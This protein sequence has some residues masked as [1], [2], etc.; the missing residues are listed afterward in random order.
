MIK[1]KNEEEIKRIR[2]SCKML[3]EVYAE[4]IPNVEPGISTKEIDRISYDLITKK[5]GKPAFLNHMGFPGTICISINEEVIHGIPSEKRTV[6]AG[7]LVSLDLGIN[8][9]GYY[10]DAAVTLPMGKVSAAAQKLVDVTNEA[11]S[12]GIAACNCGGRI[13]DIS[14]AVFAVA[15]RHNYGVVREFC[16]HGVG[17]GVHEAPQVPNYVHPGPNPRI[18]N[19][20]VLA[21]EP[22]INLGTEKVNILDDD[23]T[24]VT[25]D[26]KLSAHIEHTVAVFEDHTEI[27]TILD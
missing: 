2:E 18:K 9:G 22:M 4:I 23:W 10:S 25:A 21:I 8:L 12:A 19:G 20:L 11:L 17:F 24:V 7:D 13:K 1:L 26:S 14:K 5:G 16:G 15:D 27:L 6:K 3:A